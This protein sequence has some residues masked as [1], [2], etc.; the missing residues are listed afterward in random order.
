[1]P[2]TPSVVFKAN[3]HY[4]QTTCMT[5]TAPASLPEK[6]QKEETKGEAAKYLSKMPES[7]ITPQYIL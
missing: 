2:L 6:Q 4:L 1:M 5:K 7:F 3:S